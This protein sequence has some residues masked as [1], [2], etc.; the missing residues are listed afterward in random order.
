MRNSWPTKFLQI[1]VGFQES[2][3]ASLRTP[4]GCPLP[5]AQGAEEASLQ[6]QAQRGGV[7]GGGKKGRRR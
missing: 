6:N 4:G 2:V 5:Q 1:T 3:R 7:G